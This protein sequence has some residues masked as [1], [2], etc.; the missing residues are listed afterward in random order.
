[1]SNHRAPGLPGWW[2]LLTLAGTGLL[3]LGIYA[4]SQQLI[5]IGLTGL[6]LSAGIRWLFRRN[7]GTDRDAPGS[8]R[9]RRP[10]WWP[11]LRFRK[12]FRFL[13]WVFNVSGLRWTSTTTKLGPYSR[14]SQTGR[15]TLDLPGGFYTEWGGGK[16]RARGRR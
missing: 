13:F 1:M 5:S 10:W 2:W 12:R 14:N 16:P 6:V 9:G 15:R 8:A 4:P 11:R 7:R 3:T